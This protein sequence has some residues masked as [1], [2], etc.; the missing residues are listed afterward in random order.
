MEFLTWIL[1]AALVVLAASACDDGDDD[2]PPTSVPATSTASASPTP[3]ASTTPALSP[4][5]VIET[6][7][8]SVDAV[9][10]AVAADDFASLESLAVFDA[11]PCTTTVEGIGG[12]PECRAGEADGTPVDVLLGAACEGY[13]V[14]EGELTFE[15][16]SIGR[17]GGGNPLYGVYASSS[18]LA[19]GWPRAKYVIVLYNEGPTDAVMAFAL[20][21]DDENIVGFLDGCGATP[22]QFVE[23]QRLGEPIAGPGR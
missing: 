15:T 19:G 17:P 7:I 14:R 6:G 22:E 12:P 11:L 18:N 1:T 3:G 10:R 9:A 8:A 2:E 13:Y 21:V 20:L 4:T 23:T 5:A 16:L